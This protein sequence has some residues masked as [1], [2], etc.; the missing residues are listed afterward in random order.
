MQ[1][2][3]WAWANFFNNKIN[4]FIGALLSPQDG[5]KQY[6]SDNVYHIVFFFKTNQYWLLLVDVHDENHP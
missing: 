1:S 4:Y 5:I 6:L 2:F 3:V